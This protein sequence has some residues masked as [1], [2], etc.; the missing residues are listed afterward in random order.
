MT[1]LQGL[2]L[3]LLQGL[4]EFLPVSSSGHLVIAQHLLQLRQTPVAFDIML[5][6]ATAL[7]VVALMW[8]TIIKLDLKTFK[9]IILASIPAGI[10]GLFLNHQIETL[11]SSIGLVGVTLIITSILL[12]STKF[13]KFP[14]F[15]KLNSKSAI[16]IGLFQSLAIIPGISRSGSTIVAGL[17][18]KLNP[19][20]AFNFSFLLS[21]PAIF[22]AQLIN[23]GRLTKLDQQLSPIYLTGFI[24]AFISGYFALKILKKLVIGGK[25]HYFAYYCL[26]LGASILVFF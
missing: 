5:H 24:S 21:L 26:T 10:V 9:L 22:G 6:L 15:N 11:F 13:F 3:G 19:K 25:L 12:F 23:L 18:Q 1:L 2:L 16:L 17:S 20:K 7:A 14:H 8:P 4:T